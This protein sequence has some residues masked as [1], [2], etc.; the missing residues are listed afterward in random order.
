VLEQDSCHV[1]IRDGS[2]RTG[3]SLTTSL[4]ASTKPSGSDTP[5]RQRARQNASS[6]CPFE[7]PP[8]RHG[9]WRTTSTEHLAKRTTWPALEP[10]K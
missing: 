9:V 3:D 6:P 4:L 5:L 8:A 7:L 1:G 10:R 2:P